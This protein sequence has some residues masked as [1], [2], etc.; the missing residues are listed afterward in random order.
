MKQQLA[1]I[2]AENKSKGG[3]ISDSDARAQGG[4]HPTGHL[5]D[6]GSSPVMS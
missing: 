4:A 2:L 5:W 1:A 3:F 6:N